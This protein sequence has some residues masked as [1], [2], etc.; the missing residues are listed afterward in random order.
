MMILGKKWK[1][2]MFEQNEMN[3]KLEEVEKS[4]K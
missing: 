1:K 4:I 3:E 2:E